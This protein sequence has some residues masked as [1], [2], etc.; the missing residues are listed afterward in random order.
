MSDIPIT[1]VSHGTRFSHRHRNRST[2][3]VQI[4]S[5]NRT[6]YWNSGL[7]SLWVGLRTETLTFQASELEPESKCLEDRI[8]CPFLPQKDPVD[9]KWQYCK[10]LTESETSSRHVVSLKSR[11]RTRT[12]V[13]TG[14]CVTTLQ[15]WVALMNQ[16]IDFLFR[17]FAWGSTVWRSE[18]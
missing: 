7:L 8:V 15:A 13:W 2:L 1:N 6:R 9:W 16:F 11:N 10:F 12:H 17:Q 18:V 3:W 5:R 4:L 14:K